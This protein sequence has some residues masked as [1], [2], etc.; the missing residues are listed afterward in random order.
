MDQSINSRSHVHNILA[1]FV[2]TTAFAGAALAQTGVPSPGNS[3][4]PAFATTTAG[5]SDFF[6]VIVRDLANNP[7]AGSIVIVDFGD[8]TASLCPTQPPGHVIVGDIVRVTTSASGVA[9]FSI[10]GTLSRPSCTVTIAADG[11]TLGVRPARQADVG[12]AESS[13]PAD[14]DCPT[15]V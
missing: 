4:L 2:L 15:P 10:C 5:G 3:T 1:A 8:C 9:L 11:V 13:Y 7:I 12:H 6:Q 14:P